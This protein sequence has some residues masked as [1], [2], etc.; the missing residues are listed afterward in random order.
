MMFAND[1]VADKFMSAANDQYSINNY[2]KAYEYINRVLDL[3]RGGS[4]P[5]NASVLAETIYY[6]YL[7][8]LRA[9]GNQNELS[10]MK[11]WLDDFPVVA[12]SR[13]K[14]LMALFENDIKEKNSASTSQGTANSNQD[15]WQKELQAERERNAQERQNEREFSESMLNTFTN[16]LE[17]QTESFQD[18]MEL[19]T[20]KSESM[21][22]TILIVVL[23]ISAILLTLFILVI[24]NVIL[25]S[26][27]A[28]RQQEQF[29][30]TLQV[31]A[32]MNRIPSEKFLL[33]GV[34][35]VYGD[36]QL[37]IVGSSAQ[38]GNYLPE[39]EVDEKEFQTIR[40]FA[41]RCEQLGNEID[42]MTGR[43]NN[44]KNISEMVYKI[45]MELGIKKN[46]AMVYFC[47][48]MVYD[49]GF[50]V[51]EKDLLQAE[52]FTEE[53]KYIIRSH[54][55][56]ADN[57]FDFIP[58]KYRA[59]FAEAVAMHHENMDGSGYPAGLKGEEIPQI[60]RIIHVVESFVSLISRRNYR[61]I[62]DKESAIAELR[63]HPELYDQS[64][65]DMLDSIV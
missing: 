23:A 44:S 5:E 8:E 62:F 61:A 49:I 15:V 29:A 31:V 37:R 28:K 64:I 1:P 4:L 43:K 38:N 19:S 39:P 2:A 58:E 52:T 14:T 59:T 51:M 6:A 46:V 21:N 12:S 13:I 55:K 63:S 16:Q 60:A 40:E 56:P 57:V 3:H 18:A 65:V 35:D 48:A 17:A 54:V 26:R 30:A 33:D 45:S 47:A 24:I 50:L 27:H 25:N 20:R 36:S 42:V 32:Q 10:V 53:E 9:T 11:V 41:V 7:Q 34:V 22:K